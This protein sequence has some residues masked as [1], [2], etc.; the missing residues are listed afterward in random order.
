LA[1]ERER[2]KGLGRYLASAREEIDKLKETQG[3]AAQQA[4]AIAAELAR[5]RER[6]QQL[7]RELAAAR[8]QISTLVETHQAD[9]AQQVSAAEELARE[10]ARSKVLDRELAAAREEM[11]ALAAHQRESAEQA[12]VAVQ[13]L[14]QERARS[15]R[16]DRD[17]AAVRHEMRGAEVVTAASRANSPQK[18]ADDG[19]ARNVGE[20]DALARAAP[21]SNTAAAATPSSD[22]ARR[23]EQ[24]M[25]SPP[26]DEDKLLARAHALVLQGNIDG[27]RLWLERAMQT[28]SARAEFDLAQTYDPHMLSIWNTYG[29]RGDVAKARDLYSRAY[30][31]GITEAKKRMEALE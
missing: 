31:R 12:A 17:L 7:D 11:G 19:A 5:E 20:H 21:H 14:E 26:A 8:E 4:S 30:S 25:P 28:G 16:L 2:S 10:R 29:V 15:Q 22:T 24:T 1:R 6:S 18:D 3:S 27:A 23:A 9:A 13:A